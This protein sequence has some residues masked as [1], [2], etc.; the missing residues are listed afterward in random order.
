[1]Q[2]AWNALNENVRDWLNQSIKLPD[3]KVITTGTREKYR[4]CLET[5]F[6]TV[7]SN[8]TSGAQWNE[9]HFDVTEFKP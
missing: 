8:T 1:M 5:P 2:K 7:F 6:Y 4:K 3:G 9:D